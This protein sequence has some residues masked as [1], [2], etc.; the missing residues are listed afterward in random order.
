MTERILIFLSAALFAFGLAVGGLLDPARILGFLDVTG[1]W[2]PGPMLVMGSAVVIYA[3][4][5]RVVTRRSK[6]LGAT[7][8]LPTAKHV[9]KRLILGAVLFGVGWGL[10]GY[11]PG[12]ALAGVALGSEKALV[13]VAAM[14]AGAFIAERLPPSRSEGK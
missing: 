5:F 7:W 14:L 4:G 12:P 2:N 10:V 1:D 6:P 11:C 3:A 9:D 13:F 8:H